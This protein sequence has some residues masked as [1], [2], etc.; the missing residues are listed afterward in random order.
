MNVTGRYLGAAISGDYLYVYGGVVP[1]PEF[2]IKQETHRI[3]V[4]EIIESLKE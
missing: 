3:K 1:S 4:D 2:Y